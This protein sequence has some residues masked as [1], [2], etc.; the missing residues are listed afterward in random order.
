MTH[1]SGPALLLF[2]LALGP[3][4]LNLISEQALS[5]LDP[6]VAMALATLGVFVGLSFDHRR[7]HERRLLA[8]ASLRSVVTGVI[9]GA[10]VLVAGSFWPDPGSPSWLPAIMLGVCAAASDST[11]ADAT[12]FEDLLMILAGGVVITFI[13]ETTL[14]PLL[15]L[16]AAM[17]GISMVIAFAGWLLAGQ[18]TSERE[19]RVFVVGSLLLCGGAAAYLSLSALFVGLLAGAVWN[20]TGNL[21]RDRIV[22]DLRY[23]QHPL[24]VLLLLVAG[25]RVRI[26]LQALSLGIVYMA[27]RVASRPLA[28][29]VANRGVGRVVRESPSSLLS[30]GLVGIA[31]ALDVFQI[32]SRPDWATTLLASVVIGTMLSEAIALFAPARGVPE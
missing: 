14:A 11:S 10:A 24:I 31:L 3:H 22:R 28:G 13:R 4:G 29:W 18:T 15:L 17:S 27:S 20:V 19:Q 12:N 5:F 8:A 21:A 1:G 16:T 32:G 25:A 2:G 26:S 9:V 7:S 30:A 23:L 6:A